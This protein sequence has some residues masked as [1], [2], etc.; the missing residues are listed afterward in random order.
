MKEDK[1]IL[2]G[3]L[4]KSDW[5]IGNSIKMSKMETNLKS[6]VRADHFL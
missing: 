6:I 2:L 5:I 4:G 3:Y 1:A